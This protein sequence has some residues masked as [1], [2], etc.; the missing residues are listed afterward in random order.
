MSLELYIKE[1][2]FEMRRS[3]K[4]YGGTPLSS[5]TQDSNRKKQSSNDFKEIPKSIDLNERT[6]SPII[7]GVLNDLRD[8]INKNIYE[9]KYYTAIIKKSN[10]GDPFITKYNESLEDFLF[11]KFKPGDTLDGQENIDYVNEKINKSKQGI[12]SINISDGEDTPFIVPVF[13]LLASH[14]QTNFSMYNQSEYNRSLQRGNSYPSMS[15]NIGKNDFKIKYNTEGEYMFTS[16]EIILKLRNSFFRFGLVDV[17]LDIKNIHN[18][19]N[20]H[21]LFKRKFNDLNWTNC[22]ERMGYSLTFSEDEAK[23][24]IR[25][26]GSS[27]DFDEE[28]DESTAG[29][30]RDLDHVLSSGDPLYYFNYNKSQFNK[31]LDDLIDNL[32]FEPNMFTGMLMSNWYKWSNISS[33]DKEKL[34]SYI[35]SSNETFAREQAKIG[36]KKMFSLG[37][38]DFVKEELSRHQSKSSFKS[39]ITKDIEIDNKG[40]PVNLSDLELNKF[41]KNIWQHVHF[42]LKSLK[43]IISKS[44]SNNKKSHSGTK[45]VMDQPGATTSYDP[46]IK[47]FT[48]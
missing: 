12:V 14:I 21:N 39:V 6:H 47:T 41:Y 37:H 22:L 38:N 42:M 13:Y 34:N 1:F 23:K 17:G 18:N 24:I 31:M 26:Q 5:R 29:I 15:S 19:E 30:K 27:G 44:K 32:Y 3:R 25:D 45:A 43:F 46:V 7:V 40:N 9:C 10:G 35:E 48:K 4:R 8:D 20:I 36:F 28:N 16:K 11:R 33:G 2:L